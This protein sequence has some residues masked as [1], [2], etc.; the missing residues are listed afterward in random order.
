[1]RKEYL[2]CCLPLETKVRDFDP[3]LYLALMCIK[4]GMLSLIGSK[5]GVHM[6]MFKLKKPF[7]YVSKGIGVSD[8]PLYKK[9]RLS[10][11]LVTAL[12]EEGGVY[13][14]DSKTTIRRNN[15]TVLEYLD[16]LFMWGENQKDKLLKHAR[17]ITDD[18]IIVSGHPRFDLCKPLF[19]DYFRDVGNAKNKAGSKYVL[20]NTN[21]SRGNP[22]LSFKEEL[23]IRKKLLN[24]DYYNDLDEELIA[25]YQKLLFHYFADAVKNLS[26]RYPEILFI[27][28]PHPGESL[29]YARKV[30][31]EMPNIRVLREGS[32]Q[33]WIADALFVIH[34]DCTTAIE[35]FLSGKNVIS[36]CPIF[37]EK[38]AQEL[39]IEISEV[40]KTQDELVDTV[41]QT[42]QLIDGR[43]G[44][45]TMRE[46]ELLIKKIIANVDFS[47]AEI[48]VKE[49]IERCEKANFDFQFTEMSKGE[50]MLNLM[51]E[52]IYWRFQNLAPFNKRQSL[53]SFDKF[54][55]ITYAEIKS[56]IAA[57]RE[58]DKTIPP[59]SILQL[60]KDTFYL[61]G[62]KE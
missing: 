3:R 10:G 44:V 57:F 51:S 18:R 55:G 16:F 7:V 14:K 12:D 62:K 35:A 31:G 49:L 2:V 24:P 1:M 52:K 5:S 17:N 39:P 30:Y 20:V 19:H 23:A 29:S 61:S 54:P 47:A 41:E 36:Y 60:S 59:V 43:G 25:Y 48:I 46:R 8:I 34:H 15:D 38:Y 37:D 56:R 26:L 21:F 32:V 11:G 33:E 4:N 58:N 40:V 13:P 22:F 42:L 45:K 53:R 9:I 28:R 50:E 6:H 27:V